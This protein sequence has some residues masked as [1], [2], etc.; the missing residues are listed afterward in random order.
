MTPDLRSILSVSEFQ[1]V[2]AHNQRSGQADL[3]NSLSYIH[4]L[5][6][7]RKGVKRGG[8]CRRPRVSMFRRVPHAGEACRCAPC[9]AA[10]YENQLSRLS[11]WGV[12]R[13]RALV[14]AW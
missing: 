11:V 9:E 10:R 1:G 13:G 4:V 7:R 14:A 2:S 3:G 8:R 5:E 6:R 12:S